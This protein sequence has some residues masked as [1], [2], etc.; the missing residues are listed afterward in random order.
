MKCGPE[1]EVAYI[2]YESFDGNGFEDSVTYAR[3][4]GYSMDGSAAGEK[5]ISIHCQ[6]T[7]RG[8]KSGL[9]KLFLAAICS[10]EK[11]GER[12]GREV[13]GCSR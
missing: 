2:H 13:S 12:K 10:Q 5:E 11:T 6:T 8:E 9:I 3:H 7:D 1:P 4:D